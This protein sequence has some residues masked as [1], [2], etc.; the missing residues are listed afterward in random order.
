MPELSGPLLQWDRHARR[1]ETVLALVAQR[2]RIELQF[3]QHLRAL[4]VEDTPF[5]ERR[6]V[7]DE[8]ALVLAESC[9]TTQRWSEQAQMLHD[10]P[11]VAQQVDD[12][13]WSIR[14]ADAVLGE[15]AGSPRA[16][17][18]QVVDLILSSSDARTP[19]Q[20]RS[21]ARV[22][23][24]VLDPE[25]AQRRADKAV[26]DRSVGTYDEHN[27]SGTFFANGPKAAVAELLASLDATVGVKDPD[28]TRTLNQ[29]RF[30]HLRDL[31]TG[32][33]EPGSWQAVVLVS[34]ST[35]EG[36]DAPAEIPGLGLITA[37]EA[38][39]LLANATLRRAVVD[40]HGQ[41]VS[42]DGQTFRPDLPVPQPAPARRPSAR[43]EPAHPDDEP[44]EEHPL[45]PADPAWWHAQGPQ[46]V[47]PDHDVHVEVTLSDVERELRE[48]LETYALASAGVGLSGLPPRPRFAVDLHPPRPNTSYERERPHGGG[49]DSGPDDASCGPDS[50]PP[51]PTPPPP[52]SPPPPAAPPGACPNP[53]TGPRFGPPTFN[54]Q[55]WYDTQPLD[56][57]ELPGPSSTMPIE[58]VR[59]NDTGPTYQDPS[60]RSW[61]PKALLKALRKMQTAPAAACPAESTRYAFPAA[62]ARHLKARDITCTFP[63]CRRLARDAQNDH[64][65]EWP[66]GPTAVSNAASLCTHHHQAKHHY[67]HLKRLSDGTLRWSTP[68]GLYVDRRPRPMLRGW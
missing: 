9:G 56:T 58:T 66:K 27:G 12:G 59:I 38:R 5:G 43:P 48:L 2:D 41:L 51:P 31:V 25:A 52:P 17:Q 61:S 64:V 33:A 32:R 36:G 30:D 35:L 22:A 26:T 13:T 42:I 18:E 40:E 20:L 7:V 34:L 11:A 28:D 54:D 65:R 47:L 19:H 44:G 4:T 16:V 60:M 10:C 37:D 3:R 62:A 49:P 50:G 15:I 68:T 29:R 1:V 23:L 57:R 39:E 53:A 45:D 8:L 21:A 24:V 6:Y 67:L 55:D 63:G 46:L 14:H